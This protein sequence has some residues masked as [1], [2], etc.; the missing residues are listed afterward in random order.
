MTWIR[1]RRRFLFF[2]LLEWI[3][4]DKH[5]RGFLLPPE[6]L[7]L[8]ALTSSARSADDIICRFGL[9]YLE[10]LARI[11]IKAVWHFEGDDEWNVD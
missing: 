7:L 9:I 4:L 10:A 8:L 11:S 1:L 2:H 3:N 6:L 5:L